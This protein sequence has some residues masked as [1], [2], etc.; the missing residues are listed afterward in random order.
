MFDSPILNESV[1]GFAEVARL[2]PRARAGRPVSPSCVWR[3]ATYGLATPAGV[4]KL[5]SCAYGGRR[6][7][8]REAVA[9]FLNGV[10]AAKAGRSIDQPT[11]STPPLPI[12]GRTEAARVLDAAGV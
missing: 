8:S 2:L 9:R 11:A 6:V 10:A 7:T 5:E 12:A 3:W 4:L 1:V